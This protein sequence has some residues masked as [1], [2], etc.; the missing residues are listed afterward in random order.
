MFTKVLREG[1]LCMAVPG[2]KLLFAGH[3]LRTLDD[4]I[5]NSDAFM[6]NFVSLFV[7]LVYVYYCVSTIIYFIDSN[8]CMTTSHTFRFKF[9][10]LS[11]KN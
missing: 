8:N 7:L 3:T 1:C 10:Y 6:V 9:K 5:H 2:S 11:Y 4:S